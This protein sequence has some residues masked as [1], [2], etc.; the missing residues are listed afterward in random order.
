MNVQKIA[1]V[2]DVRNVASGRVMEKLGARR[3]DKFMLELDKLGNCE[4]ERW[5][6]DRPKEQ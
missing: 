2:V 5:T 4:M 1:A 3:T 6:L